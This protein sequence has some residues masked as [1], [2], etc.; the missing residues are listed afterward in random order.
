MGA[1]G[2]EP[3]NAASLNE[4]R[5][6]GY[7]DEL[8]NMDALER[9]K[10]NVRQA[11]KLIEDGVVPDIE[12][13]YHAHVGADGTMATTASWKKEFLVDKVVVG[14]HR[15]VWNDVRVCV[16][17]EGVQARPRHGGHAI[18]TEPWRCIKTFTLTKARNTVCLATSNGGLDITSRDAQRIMDTVLQTATR[19]ADEMKA[20]SKTPGAPTMRR[21]DDR[22]GRR[23]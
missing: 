6:R 11:V 20:K 17:R 3:Q 8:Q 21:R 23:R 9:A 2:A 12:Q 4:L 19:L 16:D 18:V 22:R 1:P 7:A 10:G 15:K 13:G 14:R 5:R